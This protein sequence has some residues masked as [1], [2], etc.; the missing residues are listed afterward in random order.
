MWEYCGMARNQAGLEKALSRSR[1]CAR[2]SRPTCGCS[3]RPDSLN[4]S[5]EKAGRVADFFELAE[6][7]CRDALTARS[8]AAATSARSTRPRRARRKRDD[9][10]FAHVTAWEWTGEPASPTKHREPLEFEYVKLTQ[11]SYK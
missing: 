9:E 6:L 3:A 10:N 1:R 5:L 7:M 8:P 4:S 2:S 11:R